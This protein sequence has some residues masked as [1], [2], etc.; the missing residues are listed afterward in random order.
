MM[1]RES[2][3]PARYVSGLSVDKN[4]INGASLSPQ[5]LHKLGVNDAMPTHGQKSTSMASAGAP[6]K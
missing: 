3:I 2:G 4:E 5:G 6:A 1:L